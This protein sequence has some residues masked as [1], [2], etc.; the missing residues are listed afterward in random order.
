M[1]QNFQLAN[2]AIVFLRFALSNLRQS[3]VSDL[4]MVIFVW[5]NI[6]KTLSSSRLSLTDGGIHW[7]SILFFLVYCSNILSAVSISESLFSKCWTFCGSLKFS[8]LRVN[9]IFLFL[10]KGLFQVF[11]AVYF[12]CFK[13][14]LLSLW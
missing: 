13:F 5:L 8:S 1:L 3:S 12:H 4:E 10:C 7:I 14:Q 6:S 2:C 11:V 9:C